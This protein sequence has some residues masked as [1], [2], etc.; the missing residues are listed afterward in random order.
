MDNIP[1]VDFS[2]FPNGS[3]EEKHRTARAIDDAFQNMGFVYL[4]NHGVSAEKVEEC[5]QWVS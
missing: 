4:T 2:A 1:V 5:F 3:E